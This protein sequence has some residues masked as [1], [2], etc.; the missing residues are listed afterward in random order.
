[1]PRPTLDAFLRDQSLAFAKSDEIAARRRT[2]RSP[3]LF[4][5]ELAAVTRERPVA[6][7]YASLGEE[8]TLRGLAAGA[9]PLRAFES[10][11][12]RAFRV[13]DS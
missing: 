2:R 12:E 8:F 13:S 7:G 1:V 9:G 6:L 10:R 5:S 3:R 11:L 4:L